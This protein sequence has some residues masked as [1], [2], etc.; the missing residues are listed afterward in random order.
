MTT[1]S[2]VVILG[3]G[4]AGASLAYE[5]AVNGGLR[6]SIVEI[7]AQPGRHATGRSA[8]MFFESYGNPTVRA[9]TRASRRFL[10]HP[11]DGLADLPLLSPR[12]CLFV[13]DAPRSSSIDAML[14]ASDRASG[15]R[16]VDVNEAM[17]R[18]PILRR[19]WLAGG[20]VDESG[21]DIDVAALH[22][23]YL[24]MAKR[25]RVDLLLGADELRIERDAGIWTVRS[26]A[27]TVAAPL[28]VNATGAWADQ[29]ATQLGARPI[30]LQPMRRTA[31]L[32]P[33]PSGHDIRDWPL[34]I[35]TDE[36][37]YFKPD[38]GQLLLSPANEDP[39]PPCDVMPEEIDV[40]LA[41]DRFERA[42]TV[43]VERIGHR[44]AGLRSFVADRSPVV[45]FD[46]D[47]E[48]LFW[49]AGQGGY[50]IQMAPGL[51]RLAAGVLTRSSWP[52]APPVSA[53]AVAP[54]RAALKPGLN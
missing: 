37:F 38:A 24:R 3:A 52:D 16:R 17:R 29:V 44:W 33:A 6:V 50:G 41:V 28:L 34:V 27:G 10:E 46:A 14:N 11:P 7:E 18:V 25:A 42:T 12:S 47:V 2:D 20:L 5:L 1:L 22:Q 51:A 39:M 43:R 19:E 45:G 32:L 54:S 23:G 30:G 21:H 53:A 48:A 8:A 13:A 36:T 26:R 4:M 40:A 31:V 15:L 49:L 35:D 9:L